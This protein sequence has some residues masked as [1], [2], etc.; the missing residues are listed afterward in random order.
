MTDY[1]GRR[2][3]ITGGAGFIGSALASRL[4]ADGAK[5]TV[6]DDFS[7]GH[8]DAV[9]VEATLVDGSVVDSGTLRELVAEHP[10]V[11]HLAARC[12]V[13]STSH[14]REDFETNVAGTLNLLLAAREC[15]VER[16]VYASSASTYG[17][18]R[19]VPIKEDDVLAPLSPY[20]A[21]K[22]SGEHYCLAFYET[23]GVGT[24]VV[25]YSNVYG[26]GQRADNPYA[27]VVT[28]FMSSAMAQGPFAVHGDGEQTR[29]F[30]FIDDAVDATLVAGR[31][32]RAEGETFNVGT[33]IETSVL[34]LVRVI[35]A[36]LDVDAEI[37]HVDPRDI[38]NIRRRVLNIE[39]IRRMLGWSPQ[40]TLDAGLRR[41]VECLAAPPIRR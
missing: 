32:P 35:A 16:V 24:A 5:V 6:L 22:L 23:Y 30:T 29:D 38:D 11:F 27:G 37:E 12:I 21:S 8:P 20:A 15:G 10:L 34:D 13:A 14:P 7:S 19:S 36:E 41:T 33:G 9:P 3:L 2:V 18:A 4:S 1:S 25:R 31:H 40:W 28:K 17:N 26:P 39:K